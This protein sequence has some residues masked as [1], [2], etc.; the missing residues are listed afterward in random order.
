MPGQSTETILAGVMA[1]YDTCPQWADP[2][3]WTVERETLRQLLAGH[4][5]RYSQDNL[6]FLAVELSFEIA[7]VDPSTGRESRHFRLAG[8]IDAIVALMPDGRVAVLEYKTAGEDIGPSSDYWPRLRCDGQISLY[9]LAARALGH[10]A[11][12]VIYDVTRKPTIRLR[13][14]ETPEAYSQRLCADIDARPDYYYQR[15][16]VPR[17]EDEL[18]EFQL[19]LWQ[20]A[21]S[22]QESMRC[23]RWYRNVSKMT[24]GNCEFSELCFNNCRI[25]PNCPPSGFEFLPDAHPELSPSGESQ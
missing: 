8:K 24:C 2:V 25:D 3:E 20:Q 21:Q 6:Q 13:Q 18:A 11:A 12:A 4:F 14:N 23:D 17:L 5:W 22:L 16:E 1:A 10:D 19:E 9:V 15:R 7:L